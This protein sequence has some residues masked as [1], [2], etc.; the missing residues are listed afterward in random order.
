M[1]LNL[2]GLRLLVRE[3]ISLHFPFRG[4]EMTFKTLRPLS[5][6]PGMP[7][8]RQTESALKRVASVARHSLKGT[9]LY[10]S[11]H[12]GRWGR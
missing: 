8:W 10:E 7:Y 6:F 2:S 11:S 1:I 12:D 9:F 4:A 5:R 3:W